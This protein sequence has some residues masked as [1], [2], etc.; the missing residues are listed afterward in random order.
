[1]NEK[2]TLLV[3]PPLLFVL[4]L[5]LRSELN[6]VI[7]H[8]EGSYTELEHLLMR[9]G[10][11]TEIRPHA[12]TQH[13]EDALWETVGMEEAEHDKARRYVCPC[14]KNKSQVYNCVKSW[15][16]EFVFA[17]S[18]VGIDFSKA[19][20]C[21]RTFRSCGVPFRGI[22][23]LRNIRHVL[24]SYFTLSRSL[25]TPFPFRVFHTFLACI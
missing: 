8:P 1:M 19:C 6:D 17:W 23:S 4:L 2:S 9:L 22:L 5:L 7:V 25:H 18:R 14:R 21:G 12:S 24:F 16:C 20:L 11:V 15:L 3:L 13:D 10:L